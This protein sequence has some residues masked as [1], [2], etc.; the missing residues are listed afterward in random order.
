MTLLRA[1]IVS[2]VGSM[3]A[4]SAM[5]AIDPAPTGE[6]TRAVQHMDTL[7]AELNRQAA[8]NVQAAWTYDA[9]LT[10]YNAQLRGE[11]SAKNALFIKVSA[12]SGR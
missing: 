12:R 2:I 10:D 9:N 6:E 11:A 7:N 4:A 1:L 8:I 3:L 5:H